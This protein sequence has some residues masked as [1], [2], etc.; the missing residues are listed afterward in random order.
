MHPS[1]GWVNRRFKPPDCVRKESG[2]PNALRLSEGGL[3]Q[4]K[5]KTIEVL[6]DD[7]SWECTVYPANALDPMACERPRAILA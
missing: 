3:A 2:D 7:L 1:L 5:N 6:T 4:R